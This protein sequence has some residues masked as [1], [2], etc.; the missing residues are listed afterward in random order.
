MGL[1]NSEAV[2]QIVSGQILAKPKE[3]PE[4]IYDIMKQCWHQNPVERPTFEKLLEMLSEIN[5]KYNRVQ[6]KEESEE[7]EEKQ[8]GQEEPI[9]NQ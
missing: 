8:D 9:Y 7:T 6:E 2:D 1:S 4:E 3:C 5:D